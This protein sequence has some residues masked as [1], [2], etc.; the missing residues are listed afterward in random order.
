MIARHGLIYFGSRVVAAAGNLAG[1]VLFTRLAGPEVYGR[2]ATAMAIAV[3]CASFA[4]QWCRYAY[5]ELYRPSRAGDVLRT[6]AAIVAGSVALAACAMVGLSGL[7]GWTRDMTGAAI[8]LMAAS[9]LFDAILEVY[10]TRLQPEAVARRW[11]TRTVL[12]LILGSVA[13]VWTGRAFTLACAV[14]AAYLAAVVPGA[15]VLLRRTD[16]RVR[17]GDAR[18]FA[19][20]G[21]PLI[22]AFGFASLAQNL[23]RLMLAQVGGLIAVGSYVAISD[24]VRANMLLLAEVCNIAVIS[25]AKRQ[26]E[27][28]EIAQSRRTLELAYRLLLLLGGFGSAAL[29]IAGPPLFDLLLPEKFHIDLGVLLPVSTLSSVLLLF[30]NNYFAQVIYFSGRSRIDAYGGAVLL[31]AIA[32]SCAVLIPRLGTDGAAFGFLAGQFVAMIFYLTVGRRAY[33]MPA[34]VR[35]TLAVAA[36]SLGLIALKTGLDTTGVLPGVKYPAEAVAF[37]ACLLGT[38]LAWT[39][40]SARARAVEAV[41]PA[42]RDW[43]GRVR[44]R[45]PPPRWSNI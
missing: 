41:R 22:L 31:A 40:R 5:F 44:R 34:P 19:S 38:V 14:T 4:V 16:G 6:Y 35:P 27:A 13:L 30:R 37:T 10:R 2:Y 8:L 7:L 1:V 12:V 26:H 39:D 3:V 18:N 9:A 20:F 32:I 25:V 21:A 36:L 42:V 33:A 23:D 29:L 43:V 11:L 24:L 17:F 45:K 28:G 15:V